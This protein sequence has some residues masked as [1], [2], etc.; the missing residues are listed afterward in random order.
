MS[1]RVVALKLKSKLIPK[2]KVEMLTR[3][4]AGQCDGCHCQADNVGTFMT[5]GIL[6][7]LLLAHAQFLKVA[8]NYGTIFSH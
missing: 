7:L 5:W 8:E 6:W 3:L 1:A 4:R 2:L